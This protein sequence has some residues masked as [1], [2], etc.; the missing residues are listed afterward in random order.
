MRSIKAPAWGVKFLRIVP[1]AQ[2]RHDAPYQIENRAQRKAGEAFVDL[3]RPEVHRTYLFLYR[4]GGA[5][6]YQESVSSSAILQGILKP[7]S[8]K[9]FGKRSKSKDENWK[10]GN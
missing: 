5:L 3:L 8:L 10:K 6:H 7:L 9:R 2:E 1:A 4:H